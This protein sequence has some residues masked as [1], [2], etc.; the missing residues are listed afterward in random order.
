M[1]SPAYQWAI[2][3]ASVLVNGL[4]APALLL[5]PHIWKDNAGL[6]ARDG[7]NRPQDGVEDAFKRIGDGQG[8]AWHDLKNVSREWTELDPRRAVKFLG[9]VIDVL[10]ATI[11]LMV[12]L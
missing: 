6:A 7:D 5:E 12:V 4:S 1:T 2:W 8:R 11:I 9:L 10:L 3:A